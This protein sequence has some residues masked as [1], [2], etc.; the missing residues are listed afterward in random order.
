MNN[1]KAS[2][3]RLP[4]Q[5]SILFYGQ[6]FEKFKSENLPKTRLCKK[7][8]AIDLFSGCGGMTEGLKQAGF[9]VIGA[10][11]IDPIAVETYKVNHPDVYVK[12]RDIRKI[13]A[14]NLMEHFGLKPGELDLLAGCPPCQGFSTIRTHNKGTADDPRNDLIFQYLRFVKRFKPK[15]IMMENTPDL[16]EDWRMKKLFKAVTRMGYKGAFPIVDA[17][18]YGV[19]QR[20]KRMVL[21]AGLHENI[22]FPRPAKKKLLVKDAIA[23]LP[24]PGKSGDPLHDYPENRTENVLNRI[25]RIPKDGGSRKDL[26]ID[27]QLPCHKKQPG[28]NDV[29]GRMSWKKESPTIT[30]GCTNPSK[31]RFLHPEE[32]RAITMREAALLQSFPRTYY[33]SL[34]GGKTAVSEMIGNAL[35]PQ[36]VKRHAKKIKDFLKLRGEINGHGSEKPAA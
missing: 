10:V 22:K 2:K 27:A 13:N 1:T 33:F 31:G 5:K 14:K 3:K 34:S 23:S 15:A 6:S 16:A 19:P 35:P 12:P 9:T 8:L 32:D 28:F 29:Y 21:M 26:G 7:Y 11:E 20:R 17:S 18:N 4:K 24:A 25:R 30:G 36:F